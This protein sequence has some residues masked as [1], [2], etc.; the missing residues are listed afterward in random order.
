[1]PNWDR[2]EKPRGVGQNQAINVIEAH[3][4]AGF[5]RSASG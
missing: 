1:M 3:C 4:G 5:V 2:S